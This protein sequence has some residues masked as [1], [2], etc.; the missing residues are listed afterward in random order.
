MASAGYRGRVQDPDRVIDS[1]SISVSPNLTPAA[2]LELEAI[3]ELPSGRSIACEEGDRGGELLTIRSREGKVELEV[4][5][6][7]A[8]PVL[9]FEAAQMQLR[10]AGTIRADCETFE[11]VAREHILQH[12]GGHL[13]QAADGDVSVTAKGDLATRAWATSITST[14]GDVLVKANDDVTLK[15]ERVHLNP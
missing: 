1:A 15:G 4:L 5:L 6:T 12:A 11:V 13:R 14:R 8:G 10:S 7:E 2:E 3:F 9:R